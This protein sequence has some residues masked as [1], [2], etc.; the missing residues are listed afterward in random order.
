V[1]RRP[2][3]LSVPADRLRGVFAAIRTEIGIPDAFAP[4]VLAEAESSAR[5]PRLPERDL[6][7]IPFVTLDPPGSMDLDQ[8]FHLERR[9]SGYRLR[10]A[11]ADIAAFVAPGGVVDEE[12]HRRIE[13]EYSPDTRTPLYPAVLSEG[14]AS[15]LPDGMRPAVVWSIE[16]DEGGRTRDVDVG[17][18]MV[19]SRAKLT[20]ADVQAS[21]EDG[22][23]D[24]MLS[25]LPE[26]GTTL[27]GA[28]RRRGG[29]SLNVPQQ[30]VVP[31]AD[32]YQLAYRLP[33]PVE[34]WNAQLSL[35]TG[36]SSAD[37]MLS[38]GI[39]VVR[40]M[41]PPDP[42]ALARLRRVAVALGVDWPEELPY[43]ELLHAL[44]V[45]RSTA[46][47]VFLRE[48]AVLFQ[49]ASYAAFDGAPPPI[50]EHAAI[51]APYAHATAP[52]RRLVDRYA[53][54]VC[55]AIAAGGDVPRWVR[56]ALPEL[57]AEMATGA[58]RS[59][60]LE[61]TTIDVVEAAALGPFIGSTFDA[62][63]ID[64]WK[65]NRGEVALSEPAVIGPCDDVDELGVTLRVTLEEA[66]VDRRTIRFA[67]VRA[68]GE[69]AA[70]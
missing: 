26:F 47:A 56:D 61:R 1:P 41:P 5:S 29:S 12:S 45:G 25:L 60:R 22:R 52:L 35:L 17:R 64:L 16:V 63:V 70:E 3:H 19:R 21:L 68:P 65:K 7:D 50:A 37:M 13:T 57:P 51:A 36:R 20:Y 38:A 24:D 30:E 10:Y 11:I 34:A 8:A 6:T 55:L 32:G 9:G 67:R 40:T 31:G 14:A 49:G 28:E 42:V 53:N 44:D 59:N 27:R 23:A 46:E 54:E 58:E 33:L 4:E 15:L 62:V 2:I 43:A 18:G 48:A 66:D 69:D 39:G